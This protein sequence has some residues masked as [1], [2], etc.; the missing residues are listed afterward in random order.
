M[1]KSNIMLKKKIHVILK[2]KL[3]KHLFNVEDYAII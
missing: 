3:E 1:V 2:E